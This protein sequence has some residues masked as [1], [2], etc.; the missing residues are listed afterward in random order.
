[1]AQMMAHPAGRQRYLGVNDVRRLN[2]QPKA[3]VAMAVL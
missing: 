1:M 2:C 3:D